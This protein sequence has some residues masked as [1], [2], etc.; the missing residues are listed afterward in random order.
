M[1]EKKTSRVTVWIPESLE[2]DLMRL[3]A[4]EDRKLSEYIAHVLLCH[5]YGHSRSLVAD[6]NVAN[7]GEQANL[8][9]L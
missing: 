1:A 3:A 6:R 7:S 8:V 5:T 9:G 2:I 4:S